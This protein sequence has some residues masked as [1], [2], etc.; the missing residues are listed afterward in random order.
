M[1]LRSR[2]LPTPGLDSSSLVRSTRSPVPPP[3]W[4]KLVGLTG[5]PVGLISRRW[6]AQAKSS[7]TEFHNIIHTLKFISGWSRFF[8]IFLKF[9]IIF[10]LYYLNI[11]MKKMI[12]GFS[13][14]NMIEFDKNLNFI[15]VRV[16]ILV[17]MVDKI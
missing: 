16:L 9:F 2:R 4:S 7:K 5:R 11:F 1:R 14:S 12:D 10:L 3:P 6:K 8:N 17:A 15:N 13:Y